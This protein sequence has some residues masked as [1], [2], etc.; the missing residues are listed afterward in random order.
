MS[1]AEL[2]AL[3]ADTTR[4][5]AALTAATL[6]AEGQQA[7][8]TYRACMLTAGYEAGDPEQFQSTLAETSESMRPSEAAWPE[9]LPATASD[10]D[11]VIYNLK[12]A[13]LTAQEAAA[14]DFVMK[15]GSAD[16]ACKPP[17]D[18]YFDRAYDQA[19]T[20]P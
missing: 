17:Y 10:A 5:E 14:D 15:A 6:S 2:A 13:K 19:L 18:L 20:N 1:S 7:I 9:P 12:V 11:R 8:A 16:R 4:A 3:D